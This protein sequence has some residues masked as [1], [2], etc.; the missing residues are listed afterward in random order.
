ME[1][2]TILNINYLFATSISPVLPNII[3][4]SMLPQMVTYPTPKS[5]LNTITP[6]SMNTTTIPI[7]DSQD[8]PPFNS[9]CF[10][11]D[12][13]S[14]HPLGIVDQYVLLAE[15]GQNH[16]YPVY[17]ARSIFDTTSDPSNLVVLKAIPATDR[18]KSFENESNIFQLNSHK[19]LLKCIEIIKNA[20]FFFNSPIQKSSENKKH[21]PTQ[22]YYNI[23]VLKY[24]A[25]GDL[26]DYVKK[27]KLSENVARYY[28]GQLL[29]ALEH[30]HEQG[31]C[32]RDLKIEN[33]IVNQNY[34]LVLADFGHSVKYKDQHGERLFKDES[35]ITTPG[36]CPPEFH[37]GA[38]YKGVPMDIFALGKLLLIFITGFNP[39]KNTKQTDET[40][41]MILKGQW[42][43]Y[44]R[45]TSGWMRKKWLK[46]DC[47][48]NDLKALLESMLNP[49]PS[50]R[51]SIQQIRE[52]AWFQKTR[53]ATSDEVSIEMIR[54]KNSI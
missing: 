47:I 37:K 46:P 39:F 8:I 31:Y 19:N 21:R 34:D 2:S 36:I 54:A 22:G 18:L 10:Q 3:H 24:H 12:H 43:A 42:A 41:S 44:W 50:K 49:D 4:Q 35:C 33:V 15:L 16:L 11:D 9:N 38:G 6:Y 23:L 27:R 25:N 48:G 51:P 45:V 32:H 53:P 28:F 5:F 26:L 29:D 30:L 17:L 13:N 14:H 7:P 20:R 1:G 52:S 40:Y